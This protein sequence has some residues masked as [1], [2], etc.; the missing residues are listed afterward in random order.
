[1]PFYRGFTRLKNG[2]YKLKINPKLHAL[3]IFLQLE[4]GMN[5]D[6]AI[7]ICGKMFNIIPKKDRI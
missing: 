7:Q 4:I 3:I 6:D 1:M 5:R 2:N